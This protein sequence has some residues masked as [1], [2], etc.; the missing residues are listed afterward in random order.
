MNRGF[1][2]FN[3]NLLKDDEYCRNI[4]TMVDESINDPEINRNIKI[5]FNMQINGNFSN[6]ISENT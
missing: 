5:Q 3:S 4:R 1:W 2:K 6:I